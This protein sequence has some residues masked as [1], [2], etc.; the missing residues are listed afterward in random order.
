[1]LRDSAVSNCATASE[2]PVD[3]QDDQHDYQQ[4]AQW[5]DFRH[6]VNWGTKCLSFFFRISTCRAWPDLS[7]AGG[8]LPVSFNTGD[9]HE[10]RVLWRSSTFGRSR[11]AFYQKGGSMAALFAAHRDLTAHGAARS[12][13]GSRRGPATHR[14][15]LRALSSRR[16][17]RLKMPWARLRMLLIKP[18]FGP[19]HLK[20]HARELS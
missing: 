8:R 2:D 18:A 11:R 19:T 16:R 6:F 10:R 13:T 7:F 12:A 5:K 3:H 15:R 9:R 14:S 17:V 1:M 4:N 20:T